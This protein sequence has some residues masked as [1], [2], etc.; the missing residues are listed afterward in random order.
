MRLKKS[1]K[2]ELKKELGRIVKQLV[3]LGA[4]KVI[5]FG[6]LAKDEVRMSSDIDLVVVL[7]D[8]RPFKKRLFDIYNEL[9]YNEAVDVIPLQR[10][11]V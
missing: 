7:E 3:K 10:P 6:S 11:G 2:K 4:K 5:L 1:R 9:E 8:Q